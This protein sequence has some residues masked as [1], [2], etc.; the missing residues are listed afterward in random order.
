MMT[1]LKWME[2][3]LFSITSIGVLLALCGWRTEW[4]LGIACVAYVVA[5]I[6]YGVRTP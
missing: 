1:F 4:M 6:S 3:I 5:V 2:R